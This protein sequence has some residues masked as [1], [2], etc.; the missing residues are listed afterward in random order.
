MEIDAPEISQAYF[1]ELGKG[2]PFVGVMNNFLLDT[3]YHKVV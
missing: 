3:I 1:G 2:L